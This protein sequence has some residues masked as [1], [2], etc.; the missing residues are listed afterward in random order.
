MSGPEA[1]EANT[2]QARFLGHLIA[3][4]DVLAEQSAPWDGLRRLRAVIAARLSVLTEHDT[5]A[6]ADQQIDPD[7]GTVGLL[8]VEL[9]RLRRV[10]TAATLTLHGGHR[11]EPVRIGAV[12]RCHTVVRTA[13]DQP[14]LVPL[15]F[16]ASVHPHEPA[17]AHR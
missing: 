9:H 7:T 15:R 4:L 16:I 17:T 6:E 10:A 11:H 8:A 2:L 5:T 1:R 13:A 14:V 3:R 12:G